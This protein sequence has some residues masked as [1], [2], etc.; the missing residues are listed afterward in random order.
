MSFLEDVL[1]QPEAIERTAV[2]LGDAALL[3]A[4]AALRGRHDGLMLTG[5]GASHAALYPA[6]LSLTA[7]GVSAACLETGELLHYGAEG[8]GARTL[9]VVVSQSGETVEIVRLL[10]RVAGRATVVGITNEPKS[11]L[12]QRADLPL[13]MDAGREGIVATRTYVA[14]LA[15]LEL[16]AAA[17][18]GRGAGAV[19]RVRGA[20][21][22]L[23]A[24]L[25]RHAESMELL[26]ER[27]GAPRELFLVGRG[28][29][30]GSAQAGALILKEASHT[31]AEPLSG[32][33]FRHGPL[34]MVSPETAAMMFAPAGRTADISSRLAAEIEGYGGRVVQ[35]GP[36]QAIDTGV[37]D[38]TLAPFVEVAAP[39]LLAEVLS[40]ARGHET[41][42]FQRMGKV[43]TEE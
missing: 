4:I 10:D 21:Q 24:L 29:S 16:F 33:H 37:I 30:F 40:R 22:A 32:G 19:D 9:L 41:G 28:P 17:L 25:A 8:I 38:E 39:E 3:R 36:G 26:G 20:A 6:Q 27:L 43:T 31:A 13:V 1:A 18:T 11:T 12:A 15:A 7:A 2:K 14:T 5:M 23:R 35:V 42:M 34:E